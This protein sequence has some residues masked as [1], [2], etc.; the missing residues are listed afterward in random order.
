M[1]AAFLTICIHELWS[2][3]SNDGME[4]ESVKELAQSRFAIH[5]VVN[6]SHQHSEGLYTIWM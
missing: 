1:I 4:E 5:P 6:K 3:D 2:D